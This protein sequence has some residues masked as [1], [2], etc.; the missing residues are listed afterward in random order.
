MAAAF[1]VPPAG[2]LWTALVIAGPG[3][4]PEEQPD[5][6]AHPEANHQATHEPPV[7]PGEDLSQGELTVPAYELAGDLQ[8]S[9]STYSVA[10]DGGSAIIVVTR[11]LGSDGE[12]TVDYATSPGSA[13]TTADYTPASGTIT[14]GPGD[15]DEQTFAIPIVNDAVVEGDETVTLTLSNP[16]GGAVLGEPSSG[17]L[18]IGVNDWTADAN[19]DGFVDRLDLGIVASNLGPPPFED[20]LADANRD[21]LIDTRD[22]ALVGLNLGRLAPQPLQPVQVERAF[23]NLTFQGLTNLVQPDDGRDLIFVTEQTGRIRVFPDDRGAAEAGTFLD[24]R[25]VVSTQGFEEGLLGL[26]FDPDYRGNGYFYVYYSAANPRRSVVSRFSVSENPNV[27]DSSSEFVIMEIGQPFSN[28]NGGQ[29]AFGPDGYLYISLGDGGSG[30]DPQGHGQNRGTLLGSVLRID[31]TGTSDDRNYLIPPDNPFVDIPEARDEIWAYGLRNPWR[32][33]FDEHTGVFWV[34]DVGQ[35]DWEEVNTV[36]RGANYGWNVMEGRHCFSPSVDCDETG[37]E[38]PVWEYGHS[39]GCSVTGGYVYRGRG[40]P[41]LLG[42]YVYGDFCSGK[43]WGL[44]HDGE[45]V[46]EQMLLADSNLRITSFGQDLDGAI[47]V[48]SQNGG[49][50]RLDAPDPSVFG[51]W[52]G[53]S[54]AQIIPIHMNL[55]PTGKVLFWQ[56]GGTGD[57]TVDEIRLWDPATETLSIPALPDRDIFCSGHSFLADGRLLVTGGQDGA[58]FEGLPNASVYDPFEDSWTR[59]AFD[60]NDRR[61]YP[62]NTTLANGDVL[63]ISGLR[64]HNG[65]KNILPQVWQSSEGAWRDLTD[66]EDPRPHGADIYPRMFLAPDGRVFKAGTD[67]ETWFLDTG[68]SGAWTQGPSSSFGR[69]VSGM[70]VQYDAGRILIVGGG[71]TPTD[72]AEVIDLNEPSPAWRSVSPMAFT[73]KHLN[74]TL[75]PDGKVLVVGG[76][77]SPGP[78]NGTRPVRPAEIWDP[79]QETWSIVAGMRLPRV[80]HSTSTLL[81]DGRVLVGGG[82]RPAPVGQ[83]DRKE[84]EIDSPPYLFKGPRPTITSVPATVTYGGTF[85]VHTR[86]ATSITD[87]N[88][89][90]LSSVT[91]EFDQNQRINKLSFSQA[92]DRLSVTAPSSGNLSPPGHYMLFILNRD[93]VPSVARIMQIVS[94]L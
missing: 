14:F 10:E 94:P 32:F 93:G 61:W 88:W 16:T 51:E 2:M 9:T 63:V 49:I 75:L 58:D 71:T 90:R 66:A 65:A 3:P 46:T 80:Y 77:S 34:A 64:D 40:I 82:G 39:E 89:I 43:I 26:A 8:F 73:R 21:G 48:L 87:V 70:A 69:R 42:A 41:S 55:L 59:I 92:Q 86:D 52:S 72:T 7:G 67:R 76:T 22:L 81:P 1:L 47:Y 12:V 36:E 27:A 28:H 29:L 15:T 13:S 20:P 11:T 91:H 62:T 60:M 30:G 17:V 44:R 6:T 79:E 4:Q 54:D 31:V 5:A 56:N 38:L 57:P 19:E 35:S 84:L 37:L 18:I 25:P 24:I 23:P 68:G 85:S 53:L 74:A 45:F 83:A 33:S 78:N 50:Y